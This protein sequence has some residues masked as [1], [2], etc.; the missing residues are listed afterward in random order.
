MK[1]VALAGGTGSAKLLRGLKELSADLTVVCNV[2]DNFHWKGLLVCPD[3]DIAMYALAGVGD[4]NRGWGIEGDTFHTLSELNRL[5]AE[6]WFRVGDRD[7]ATSMIRTDLMSRGMSLSEATEGLARKHGLAQKVIPVT[8]DPMET[9][10]LTPKGELH[11]QEFWVRD[12]GRGHVKGVAYHGASAGISKSA[13]KE[14]LDADRLVVCP[15]NPVTSIGP[16]LAVRGVV[17]AL[18]Q[19]SGRISALSPMIGKGPISGPA[20]KLMKATGIRPDSVGVAMF[21]SDFLDVMIVDRAD[22]AL[23]KQVEAA[24]P[25]CL[26]SDITIRDERD[27]VRLA[28]ELIAA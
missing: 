17:D 28:R 25:R 24:G 5:G 26:L 20:G 6:A 3:I 11:L 18:V 21:Y 15:A 9:H 2:G 22:A 16:M 12:R 14:I 7:L 8:D 13:R 23:R 19:T 1:V 4:R 10:I 27:A